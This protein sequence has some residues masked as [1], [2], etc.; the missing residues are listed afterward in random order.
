MM[1]NANRVAWCVA[2]AA[3]ML[4]SVG[5][6]CKDGPP[7][8]QMNSG[9]QGTAP[10]SSRLQT[11]YTAMTDNALLNDS[12]MSSVHFV[13]RTAELNSLGVRRLT[14]V[15]EVLKIYGG[16]VFYD[17]TDA[18]R[19]LRKD[20]VEKIRLFLTSCGVETSRFNVEQGFAGA[21]GMD[22]EEA[23]AI[24]KATRGPGD[25]K[26]ESKTGEYETTGSG[27]G[28]NSK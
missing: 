4:V 15:A 27:G 6:T 11:H 28:G 9:P 19:D 13:P 23:T 3:G 7:A 1:W 22:A 20:R 14:R 8:D 2:L 24:R 18:E 16:T 5:C 10:T 17:G 26:I 21:T 25:V 12:S